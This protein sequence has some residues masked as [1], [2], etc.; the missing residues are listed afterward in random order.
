MTAR[1]GGGSANTRPVSG[2]QASPPL[3]GAQG[4][5]G[6]DGPS[7]APTPADPIE[8]ESITT[9][10][11]A[12]LHET[13]ATLANGA[14]AALGTLTNSPLAGNPTKWIAINDNGTTRY[15]PAW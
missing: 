15:I 8:C 11:T 4:M 7:F 3:Q 1:T 6:D 14:A 5:T 2:Q 12:F 10:D 13:S 9:A